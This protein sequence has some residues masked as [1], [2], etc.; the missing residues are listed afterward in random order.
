MNHFGQLPQN[1]LR[2]RGPMV[3]QQ[4]ADDPGQ[5]VNPYTSTQFSFN[6]GAAP[7]R[8][9][10]G[11]LRRTYL[12]IQNLEPAGGNSIYVGIGVEPTAANGFLIAPNGGFIEFIGGADGGGYCP[13]GDIYVLSPIGPG[14]G[15]VLE[16]GMIPKEQLERV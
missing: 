8:V 9:V 7:L 5:W 10:A 6:A 15:V 4:Y 12:L 14:I 16:G 1:R 3:G 11:N 13:R 2:G